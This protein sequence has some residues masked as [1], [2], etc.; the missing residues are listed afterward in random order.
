MGPCSSLIFLSFLK[1]SQT[2]WRSLG[3][4]ARVL[5]L[6]SLRDRRGYLFTHRWQL[7]CDGLTVPQNVLK[8]WTD[9]NPRR[10]G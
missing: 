8:D 10:S 7:V 9:K 4:V 6:R 5:T 2:L 3:L 1:F